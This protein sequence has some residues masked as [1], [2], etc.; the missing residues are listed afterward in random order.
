VCRPL[1][2][3]ELRQLLGV[4]AL[5]AHVG[6]IFVRQVGQCTALGFQA[7]ALRAALEEAAEDREA[8]HD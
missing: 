3:S 8:V 4:V 7:L 5:G 6:Q 2:R 1:T